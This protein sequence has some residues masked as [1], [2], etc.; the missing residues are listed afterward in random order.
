MEQ[1]V[2][3]W[4]PGTLAKIAEESGAT[5]GPQKDPE[6]RKRDEKLRALLMKRAN[7]QR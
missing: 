3:T 6:I 2:K 4:E 5:H 7:R 1:K